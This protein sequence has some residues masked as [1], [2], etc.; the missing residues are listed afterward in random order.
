ML[1]ILCYIYY[2]IT[3]VTDLISQLL[4]FEYDFFSSL[5]NH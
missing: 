1:H 4:E 2:Y 5:Q 3:K